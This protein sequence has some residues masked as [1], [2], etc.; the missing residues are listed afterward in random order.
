MQPDWISFA[1]SLLF[2][3][4]LL[5]LAAAVYVADPLC[6]DAGAGGSWEAPDSYSDAMASLHFLHA[7][8]AYPGE[9]IPPRQY[10]DEF[11][12]AAPRIRAARQWTGGIAAGGYS[13]PPDWRALGPKNLGGRTNALAIN[14]LN[15]DVIY[16]GSA[17]GGL[18]RSDTGGRGIEAWHRIETGYPVLG[19]NAIA[20]DPSDTATVYIG[21]GEVYGKDTSMGGLY[22][23]ITRGSYGI[24]LLKSTDSG[25]TWS[26][27]IDWSYDQRRG[28]L[29]LEIDPSDPQVIFAGTTEGVYR[30]SD[31]GV[32]WTMVLDVQ[33]AVDIAINPSNSDTIFASCGNLGIPADA[34]VYRSVDGG[35]TWTELGG[36][37]PLDWSGK[38]LLDIYGAAP[39]VIYADVA[40]M[41]DGIGL[42]RS[43]DSGDSWEHLTA[44][45]TGYAGIASYQGWF[46]HYVAVNPVDS[47]QVLVAGVQLY[48]S[49]D[50]GRFFERTS[51]GG[52]DW[53]IVPIGGP[54]GDSDYIHVD[55][56]A[57][58][59][60]PTDPATLFLGNDGGVW[61]TNDFGE[62]FIGR[63]GYYQTAQFYGG[64]TSS[65][66]DSNLAM[67]GLQ[68]NGTIIY[69]GGP[70]WQKSLGG[71]GG[72]TGILPNT[73]HILMASTQYCRLYKSTN[74]GQSWTR[75]NTEMEDGSDRVFVAPFVMAPSNRAIS[76]AGRTRVWRSNNYI[77]TWY[78]PGS[79]PPLDGNPVLTISVYPHGPDI[80]W[81]ATVPAATRAGVF[82]STNGGSSWMNITGNLPDRYPVDIVASY[83]DRDTA[84][85]VFSGFGTSHLFRTGDGGATWEDIDQGKL[86]D[87]PTSAF[88][89]DPYNR[90]YL[91]LGNDLGVWFSPDDGETWEPFTNGLPTAL[92]MD[93]SIS[94]ADWTIRAAVHGLGA[95]ERTLVSAASAAGDTVAPSFTV[96]IVRNSV[97]RNYVDLYFVPSEI[98]PEKP[99]ASVN[100]VA[101]TL[102][103]ISTS[104]RDVY[105]G[106]YKLT[107]SGS[108]TIAVSG[109]DFAGNDTLQT[110][111]FAAQLITASEGGRLS[112]AGG[113]FEADFP[114]RALSENEYVIAYPVEDG[115]DPKE[116]ITQP[117]AMLP[118]EKTLMREMRLALSYDPYEL[119]GADPMGLGIYRRV[120][121][122][123]VYQASYVDEARHRVEASIDRLGTYQLRLGEG[124]AEGVAAGNGLEQNYPNPFNGSTAIRYSIAR[125]THVELYVLNVRGQLVQT[126]VDGVVAAGSH[127]VTWD[128][129]G[130]SGLRAASGIYLIV[131]RADGCIFTR[132]A[133]LLQ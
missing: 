123:W 68:D 2:T 109:R 46:S 87:V 96:G 113:T 117:F 85:I 37:L 48:K 100:S 69:R 97:L 99:N 59:R 25:A 44:N 55:H 88:A 27:S 63:N 36:G 67:G 64:F 112:A 28:V 33:M 49:V 52:R 22:I 116:G 7:Q 10:A 107:G 83:Y 108:Y 54:E 29:A 14:P 102:N 92:V 39:N 133:L 98:L 90:N 124:G 78:V 118:L 114:P 75:T 12:R 4:A 129:K 79:A 119:G 57:F 111:E 89:I 56:H 60:H 77:S 122:R 72:M 20:I 30:S 71:D 74:G 127:V 73:P 128:G 104:E 26:K 93:L 65:P 24:G 1:R 70:A 121:D 80:V 76:Y 103:T 16:A 58:A 120:G 131:L 47:S 62:S 91:Y 13:E 38:T 84:Y 101:V 41:F 23:R 9:D 45:Y 53:G 34:G 18:W 66:L 61:E 17:S 105:V 115:F 15:P 132:K 42:Y 31:R 32:T 110:R 51:L 6:R 126:I 11:E 50:G 8:R 21:T 5:F 43:L 86:P 81:A 106:D 95:W 19:V 125:S 3:A 82:R 94:R 130:E 35:D 40:D